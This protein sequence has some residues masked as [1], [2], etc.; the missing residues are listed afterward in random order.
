MACNLM[1]CD[2]EFPIAVVGEVGDVDVFIGLPAAACDESGLVIDKGLDNG[3]V[4]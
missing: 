3:K 2:D 4:G 1:G